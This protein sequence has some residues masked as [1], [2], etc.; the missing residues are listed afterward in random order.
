M[1]APAWEQLRSLPGFKKTGERQWEA[2]CPGH[3]DRKA[4]LSIGTGKDGRILL[5]CHAGCEFKRIMEA[6]GIRTA[7]LFPDN[8][9]NGHG[10]KQE[11]RF[12]ATYDYED[13]D[14][15]LVYQVV[16][17]EPKDFR[18]RR[19]DGKGGWIWKTGDL[20]RL[21]YRLPELAAA[22]YIFVCEGE[23]DCDALRRI[24]LTA[25]CNSGGAGK[26][27]AELAQYF[28]ADQFV[29]IL[30]DNDDPGRSH[31]KQVAE[32]LYGKVVSVKILELAGL[33]EKGDV[34]DWLTGREARAANEE[35]CRLSEAAPEWKPEPEAE[36]SQIG[37]KLWDITESA[38]WP[39]EPLVWCVEPLIPKGGIGFM[40]AAPKDRKSLLSLDLAL[41]L[42]QGPEPRLWLDQYRVTPGK[43]LYI[44]REDPA[45]RIKE[46]AKEICD[47]YGMPVP[48]P[49]RLVFLIRERISLTDPEHLLW[50]KTQITEGR[51]DFLILDVLNRMIPDLDELSAKD[52]GRMVSILEELNRDLGVTILCDDHTRKPQGKNTGRNSQEPNPFDLKGSVAKYGC[53]DFMICLARTAQDSRMQVYVENKDTDE[54]PHFMVEVSPKGS[55]SP[56]F[57]WACDVEKLAGDMRKIGDENRE[58]VFNA[59]SADEWRGPGEV[60]KQVGLSADTVSRH[61]GKLVKLG[62]LDKDGRGAA[63]K[64][65]QKITAS[66]NASAAI[67]RNLFTLND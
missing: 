31:A 66:E 28:R 44:A 7:D 67:E 30:P 49:R 3:D 10:A 40:S 16:R 62:R 64:Y 14:G 51:F 37:W 34:S 52:M 5:S 47:S 57:K 15:N 9:G 20:K 1:T 42:A 53:A 59:Y 32:S 50:L 6:L 63:T 13:R 48:D 65:R 45:R 17:Y 8:R 36:R 4:S 23:K 54:R 22:D 25:T 39:D 56:K 26:W 27:T 46:R 43:V 58:K 2:R 41:H 18:Q 60:A 55:G 12:V 29:T 35:L 21:P 19:P 33:P 11:R 24:A 61:S 38:S